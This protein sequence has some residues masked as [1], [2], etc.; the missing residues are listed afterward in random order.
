ML[1]M[2]GHGASLPPGFPPRMSQWACDSLLSAKGYWVTA[3]E[4]TAGPG[5]GTKYPE[6]GVT[7]SR[8]TGH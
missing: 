3:F 6:I 5:A 8:L 4:Q 1:M 7:D 2:D